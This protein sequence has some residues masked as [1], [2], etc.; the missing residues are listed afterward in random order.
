[1]PQE[2]WNKKR[3]RHYQHIKQQTEER[4]SSTDRAAEIAARTVNKDRAQSGESRRASKSSL[5][6]VAPE[7]RGGKRSG[8]RSGPGGQTK[9]QLYQDAK[10]AKIRG[11]SRMTK[12][13][14]KN[15]LGHR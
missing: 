4:G 2:T 11:R 9:A 6:D 1:M 13:E 15:A 3:E 14:L 8:T 10:R 5:R 7:H 12:Q